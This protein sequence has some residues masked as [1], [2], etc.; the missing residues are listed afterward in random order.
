VEMSGTRPGLSLLRSGRESAHGF[1][2]VLDECE[3][4]LDDTSEKLLGSADSSVEQR[5]DERDSHGDHDK[6]EDEGSDF[7]EPSLR[8]PGFWFLTHAHHCCISTW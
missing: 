4:P 7:G 5:R 2:H 8:L 6:C 3:K 1:D